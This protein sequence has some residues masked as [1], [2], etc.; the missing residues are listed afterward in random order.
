MQA[1]HKH[2]GADE[3]SPVSTG[4]LPPSERVQGLI[5]EAYER[6]KS[7]DE[8]QN[9]SHYPALAQMPRGLFG[10]CLVSVNGEAY[11]AGEAEYPFMITSVAKP[12][13]FALICQA[14]G[15]EEPRQKLG[16]NSTGLPF[17]SVMALELNQQRLTNPM[18][19]AGAIAATSLAPGKTA[20]EKWEFI[21]EGLSRFAGRELSLNEKVY[22][23]ASASNHRNRAI[24]RLLEGYGCKLYQMNFEVENSTA[25]ALVDYQTYN[26][27]GYEITQPFT[28]SINANYCLTEQLFD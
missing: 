4:H 1:D 7:N 3:P 11:S 16:V 12:F 10:L 6:Y 5:N 20:R 24:A 13:V 18:V 22:A 14:L 23:S 2:Q 26:K 27:I 21:R 28:I 9:A 19:N 8:G 17:N 15:V 25:N